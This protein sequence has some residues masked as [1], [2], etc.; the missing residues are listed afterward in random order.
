MKRLSVLFL[1]FV[2]VF[3][4]VYLPWVAIAEETEND[5]I[6]LDELVVTAT[7]KEKKIKDLPPSIGVVGRAEIEQLDAKNVT[8]L[9]SEVPGVSVNG[10]S[11]DGSTLSISLRGV[12]PSRTNKILVLVNG[13][14]MN[15]AWT[16]TV[17]WYDLPSPNQIERIEV[18]KGP[19]SALYG[20]WGIGGCVNIITRRGA[21]KPETRIATAF[22][23]Y[24]A[25]EYSA[26]TSGNAKNKL[27]YQ[28]GA[29][30]EKKDG[31]RDRTA[32][33][34]VSF[35]TKLG[36]LIS[37]RADIEMDFGYSSVDTETA[38]ALTKEQY[39]A[40]PKQAESQ[41]GRRE[42]KRMIYNL[43]FRQDVGDDDSLRVTS[44]YNTLDYDYVWTSRDSGVKYDTY[45]IGGEIQYTLNH[46]LFGRKNSL[47][48]G[49]TIRYDNAEAKTFDTVNGEMT[50]DPTANTVSKPMFWA[51]YFQ[52][53]C[54]VT[55]RLTMTT[56]VRY[57]KAQY[58]QENRID[59]DESGTT[60][61]DAVS[62]MLGL[63]YRLFEGTTLF[64]NIGKGFAPPSTSKLYG[65]NGNP[66]LEPE[67]A[68]NY[69]V[70]LRSSSLDW[71]DLTATIY[72]MDVED[73]IVLADVNGE[74]MYINTGETRHEG[75]EAELD[76]NLPKGFTPFVN[77]TYQ[78]AE[79]TDYRVYNSRSGTYS[80]YDGKKVPNVSDQ[81]L[82]AGIKYAHPVGLNYR[83][84]ARYDS[85]KYTD[86]AN[87]Y[88]VPGYTV[89]DTRLGYESSFKNVGY[90][91]YLSVRN[92]FDKKY[93]YKGS[94]KGMVYPAEPRTFMA[95]V[96]L[97]F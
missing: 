85:K 63:S 49:P 1:Q 42:M 75:V 14:P 23:S 28:L 64:G 18:I 36:Y 43:T 9:I 80:V 72:L 32:A 40:D 51:V 44:Y 38:G 6:N 26:E 22:G 73:E 54:H 4:V 16:G 50:G 19:A 8:E 7:R 81:I 97:K 84:S 79:Y 88:D 30:Y 20:G 13:I 35:S 60:S 89:W 57:D 37:D 39:E 33:E 94:S 76:V 15:S 46:T 21:V 17:Y 95:G 70:G 48:F 87:E 56:G 91:A 83:L 47:I 93:Y 53:E 62:P 45:T 3:S 66:D 61:M 27:T 78:N 67:T 58:D 77:Y 34:N 68:T 69:E 71:L 96:S 11:G 24:G 86:S 92:L 55:D 25:M 59:T 2:M 29:N 10:T 65:T 31:Y 5:T 41:F 52:D 74:S 90:S 82:I 12:N